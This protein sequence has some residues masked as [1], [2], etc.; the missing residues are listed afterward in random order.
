MSLSFDNGSHVT[1]TRCKI[2]T[3]PSAHIIPLCPFIVQSS[4]NSCNY[5]SVFYPYSSS[6]SRIAYKWEPYRIQPFE[7][8]FSHL[9]W[10]IWD[11]SMLL[12]AACLFILLSTTPLHGCTTVYW[13]T[14]QLK[15]I[16][17]VS[18]FEHLQ[19]K[20]L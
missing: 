16:C 19:I 3:V 10:C 11:P 17:V 1:T 2:R 6:F 9:A 4:S 18:S 20:S 13:F 5:W 12:H 15:Y 7:S 14:L 8:G